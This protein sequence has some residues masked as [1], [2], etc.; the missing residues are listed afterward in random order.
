[1]S[2]KVYQAVIKYLDTITGCQNQK[3]RKKG[4]N[5]IYKTLKR[6]WILNNL[7]F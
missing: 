3:E 1:M 7:V 4:H 5:G 6:R 2:L